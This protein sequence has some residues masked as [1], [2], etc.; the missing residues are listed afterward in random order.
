M[1]TRHITLTWLLIIMGSLFFF[2]PKNA[3]GQAADIIDKIEPSKAKA[4]TGNLEITIT[5]KD[6]GTPPVPPSEVM[7]T[8]VSIG[9]I[10][11]IGV[12]R[13]ELEISAVID[14][15]ESIANGFQDVSIS[16]P[17]PN[18][19]TITF[20]KSLA[21]EITGG[22]DD[23]TPTYSG[24]EGGE[25]LFTP[26]G[27]KNTYLVDQSGKT[28]HTWSST[29]KP[30]LSCYLLADKSLLRTASWGNNPNF[31]NAAGKGGKI[32][33]FDWNGNKIWEFVLDDDKIL[34][35][36]DIEYLPNGNILA[37]AYEY[38]T[39]KEAIAAGRKTDLLSDDGLWSDMIIEIEPIY[40]EGG[41]IVWQWKVWD[42]LIQDADQ[43]K[44]NYGNISENAGKI[45]INYSTKSKGGDWT[46]LNAID[47]NPKLDHILVTS[48][49]FSEIWI[50][51][52]SLSTVE[53]A[54]NLGDLIYRWGNPVTYDRGTKS[55]QK[56]FGPHDGRWIDNGLPGEQDILI[57][58]NGQGRPE[59]NYSS[60]DQITTPIN[61]NIKY[62]IENGTTYAPNTLSW[63]YQAETPTDFYGDHI[64]GTQR[65]KGG[66]TLICEG[67]TGR[68][69][70]V[71]EDG[72]I[73]W[74]YIN[75][76]YTVAQNGDTSRSVF[77]A[78]RYDIKSMSPETPTLSL[79]Y[80][81]VDTGQELFYNSKGAEISAPALGEDFYGQ[82]AQY[83][84]N[85]PN[86]TD[87]G[88]GT[89]TDNVT[90]LMWSKTSDLNGDGIIDVND[91]LTQ[92]QAESQASQFNL[93]GYD[94]WRLPTIKELYSLIMFF[95]KDVS[96]YNGSDTENLEPFI[97]TDYFEF[98]YGDESAGERIIDAQFATSTIY[99]STTMNGAKTMF[100]VNLADG[101]IKG[102]PTES[103]QGGA[104]KLFYVHYVRGNLDYGKNDFT[105]NEDGTITDNATGLMWSQDDSKS[106]LNWQEALE[107]VNQKNESNFLGYSDWRLPNVKE[108]QSIVDYTR[109][110]AASGTA[111]IDP[112]FACS[113]IID[114]GGNKNFPFYWSGTTHA[115]MQKG[116][117]GAYVAFGEGLGFMTNQQSGNTTLMDVHGAGCQR[118]DPKE[119]NPDDYPTGHGPQGDVIRI[120]NYVRLVRDYTPD[121][122]INT[123]IKTQYGFELDQ[124]SPNP[125]IGTTAISFNLNQP[126]HI[127][128]TV[129]DELGNIISEIANRTLAAGRYSYTFDAI[130][131]NSGV[132]YY[133]LKTGDTSVTKIMTVVR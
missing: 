76:Y 61:D 35:H 34:M 91:K 21:F 77:R 45:N 87:N 41:K 49:N 16:F 24:G 129:Y 79:T 60:I 94:D 4:G 100:G 11:A 107:W 37:L 117:S 28:I 48:R 54:G 124:N 7:P 58:N 82:D 32:E 23:E 29:A 131:L 126:N 114:E 86:Y 14:I 105:D 40:P 33:R 106:G 27:S 20:N 130:N 13:N 57:F 110:P 81:I 97:N 53:T 22:K 68:I 103:M 123:D 39:D 66:N 42:H 101:R 43:N 55:D 31:A 15:P 80:P 9:Q 118:S 128:L 30:A 18:N 62:D 67:T 116:A 90:G 10:Q 70:E 119:G 121:V 5:M 89:I 19:Q 50:I 113:E 52:H 25:T 120:Y 56:L 59:G 92:A 1:T 36:H 88:D 102:Y 133:T 93:A 17:G 2:V 69:F 112:I 127:N 122:G 84:G 125:V 12:S 44:P 98:G 96:G 51:D 95:G 71:E 73:A 109:S 74:Q 65:L 132:Y 47:Y 63:T 83:E 3:L 78:N 85:L 115:N 6:L 111:A 46:H 8:S 99:V 38:K 72:S 75:P 108:L 26:I 64:S 104:S